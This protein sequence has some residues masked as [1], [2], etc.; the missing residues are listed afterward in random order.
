MSRILNA[1]PGTYTDRVLLYVGTNLHSTKK[2]SHY[3]LQSLHLSTCAHFATP[4]PFHSQS[5]ADTRFPDRR[6]YPIE[7]DSVYGNYFAYKLFQEK[8]SK[9]Q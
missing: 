5:M 7:L 2:L 8:K 9:T 4:L 6:Q 1:N 3:R